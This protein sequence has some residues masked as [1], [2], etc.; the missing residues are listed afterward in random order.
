MQYVMKPPLRVGPISS[1]SSTRSASSL[2]LTFRANGF[3]PVPL[4]QRCVFGALAGTGGDHD[5]V[6]DMAGVFLAYS[7]AKYRAR[8][9]R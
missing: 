1:L 7:K 9:A 6:R 5:D 3:A 4:R 2:A 8:N